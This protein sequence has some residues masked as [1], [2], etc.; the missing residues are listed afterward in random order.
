V[1]YTAETVILGSLHETAIVI[2]E[3]RTGAATAG[4]PINDQIG[5]LAFQRV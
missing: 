5:P 4:S 2:V 1:L 3:D